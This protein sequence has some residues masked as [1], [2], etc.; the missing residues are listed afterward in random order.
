MK[1]ETEQKLK[2]ATLKLSV[3]EGGAAS[4]MSGLTDSYI[5]P[6]AL[7]LNAN[8]AQIGFLSSF[9][10]LLAPISQI[11][12][13]RLMEKYSR[14]KIITIG[15]TLHALML[16]PFVILALFF[17]KN[18]F[19]THLATV[20]IVFY[21]L[22]AVFGA[23]AGPAWFSLLGDI[24]PEEIRGKYF[25]RRNKICGAIA[26]I[27]SFVAAF[28]LD[29][30][31]TKGFVLLGFSVLFLIACIARLISASLFKK[32]YEP[33]FK[34]KKDYYFS[35]WQFIKKA[36][37]NNFGKFV[38]FASLMQLA[39]NIGGIFFSVYMLKELKFSYLVFM[40]VNLSAALVSL[41]FMPIW[42]K[43]SD[44][45]GNRRLLKI[46]TILIAIFPIFWT[47]NS[48][49]IYLILVPQI[50][51][52]LGWAAFNLGTSNFIYD[53]V[54][55]PRRGICVAYFNV[56]AGLGIFIGAILGGF[57]AQ[58]LE[59][60]FMSIYLFLFLLS[61]LVRILVSLIFFR[62]IK[63]VKPVKNP[64]NILSYITEPLSGIMTETKHDIKGLG[65]LETNLVKSKN[66]D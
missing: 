27:S 22:Y 5:T 17:W 21:S 53:S 30:F 16:L 55:V 18:L 32:H 56:L 48:S 40:L 45:Y 51:S 8:N 24:V 39:V 62:F 33:R 1:K 37:S 58:Y 28:I 35:I 42:G 38:L 15:V 14:K 7:T 4:I 47:L 60:S 19:S 59:I 6:F 52:G 49:P 64:K 26:L 65:H 54:S 13:S 46:G 61:A 31:K 20:L 41:I 10:S 23:I 29:F 2:E 25:G 34:L 50:I 11:L 43:F 12:G 9:A 57:L 66:S 3:K 63:E 44:K 36:P